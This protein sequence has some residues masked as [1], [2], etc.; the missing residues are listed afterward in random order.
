MEFEITT[1]KKYNINCCNNC[2]F[3][4]CEEDTSVVFDSFDEPNYIYFCCNKDAIETRIGKSRYIETC[5]NDR[6][7][8]DI[9]D[10]CPFRK[11]ENI[12]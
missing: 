4:H 11:E 6:Q 5:F 12:S 10:W 9:P 1:T 2:P 7:K 3:C 8:C